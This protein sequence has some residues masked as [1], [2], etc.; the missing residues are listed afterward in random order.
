MD[1]RTQFN[2]LVSFTVGNTIE[3]G[4]HKWV[5]VAHGVVSYHY[6]DCDPVELDIIEAAKSAGRIVDRHAAINAWAR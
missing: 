2:A 4:D 1:I 6:R 3:C 5:P